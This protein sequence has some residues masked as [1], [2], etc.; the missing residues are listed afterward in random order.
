MSNR[1]KWSTGSTVYVPSPTV[2]GYLTVYVSPTV[3]VQEDVGLGASRLEAVTSRLD[4]IA[5]GSRRCRAYHG[6]CAGV[7][8]LSL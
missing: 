7:S 1:M 2:S 3:S 4:A 5:V 8:S 6:L